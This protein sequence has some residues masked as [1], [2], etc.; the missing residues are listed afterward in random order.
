M[1][2]ETLDFVD[3][4]KRDISSYLLER[5]ALSKDELVDRLTCAGVLCYRRPADSDDDRWGTA[6]AAGGLNGTSHASSSSAPPGNAAAA[7][8][9]R[10]GGPSRQPPPGLA[11][12]G[13]PPH[14][15]GVRWPPRPREDEA[16]GERTGSAA[17]CAPLDESDNEGE[18]SE[19][20]D[21][22]DSDASESRRSRRGG[23]AP[24]RRPRSR[25]HAPLVRPPPAA[26][27]AAQAARPLAPA[28]TSAAD[29][30]E[31]LEFTSCFESGNLRY[32]VY[33]V[34][35]EA[36]DLVLENDVNTRGHTQWFYF[37]VRNGRPG[38]TVRLR[39]INMS[40]AK[41]LFRLGMRP[42]AWSEARASRLAS[43]L[44]ASQR[45]AARGG[46]AVSRCSVA[47]AE[48]LWGGAASQLW[49]PVGEHV[50]Y[51]RTR[52][53]RHGTSSGSYTLAF[54]YTFEGAQR[55]DCVFFAMGVPFTY[56]MLR[57]SLAAI[58]GD[59]V[60]RP[61]CRVKCLCSTLGDL[62][63]DLLEISNWAVSKRQK[64]SVVVSA[65]V[66]PGESNASWL[67]HGLLGFLLS[68]SP[69]AKVLR[70][71][72]VWQIVPMM[73]PDGVV[74]GNYRCALCGVDLNRQWRRPNEAL[75][76]SVHGLKRLIARSKKKRGLCMYID[77]HGH[78]R[79]TGLFSYACG[80]YPK[81]DYRRFTVRMY[82]KL[83]GLLTPEFAPS[84]C[85]W[86]VGKG[87]RGTGRVVVAKDLGLTETYT[88][89]ASFFG[90][91]P[92]SAGTPKDGG[93]CEGEGLG[94]S[95]LA[96]GAEDGAAEAPAAASAASPGQ[97]PPS[98]GEEAL[99]ASPDAV[100]FTTTK[101]ELFGANLARALIP[102]QNLHQQLKQA[103]QRQ[104]G[105]QAALWPD[106]ALV[107]KGP[108][109]AAQL[110]SGA[111][112]PSAAS[113]G[114]QSGSEEQQSEP[115]SVREEESVQ[116]VAALAEDAGDVAPPRDVGPLLTVRSARGGAE[117]C[118]GIDI[119]GV[120]QE[121]Q[122]VPLSSQESDSCGSDSAPSEDNLAAE[123]L[124]HIGRLLKIRQKPLCR[125]HGGSK[126]RAE[127]EG[128]GGADAA[129][130]Q[131]RRASGHRR[132]ERP[133]RSGGRR[134]TGPARGGG[135]GALAAR[136]ELHRI[137]AFG[138]TTYYQPGVVRNAPSQQ[139]TAAGV[140]LSPPSRRPP[141]RRG[142]VQ[143]GAP[144][145]GLDLA[146]GGLALGVTSC[147]EHARPPHWPLLP[148][149][150][151]QATPP[152]RRS[153]P[154]QQP[155]PPP[156]LVL[157][158]LRDRFAFPG[159]GLRRQAEG[160][161]RRE[162]GGQPGEEAALPRRLH[163]R[164]VSSSLLQVQRRPQ[165]SESP[166]EDRS[167]GSAEWPC[168]TSSRGERPV[169]RQ[170][171]RP[172]ARANSQR[173]EAS[174][175]RLRRGSEA[176]GPNTP[177]EGCGSAR[178]HHARASSTSMPPALA[179]EHH[180]SPQS[181]DALRQELLMCSRRR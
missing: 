32:V 163:M 166:G 131:R 160:R 33:S 35:D 179:R 134:G 74:C 143:G 171:P 132:D 177:R 113:E 77:L 72:F 130:K 75:H 105:H 42:V 23:G 155:P 107:A 101:L 51:H 78:S 5:P 116:F 176:W 2:A 139:F 31:L 55:S 58:M 70:D 48:R 102:H 170:S 57:A 157:E 50:R 71:H 76:S 92:P 80:Q 61:W 162:P 114:E 178:P 54:E 129:Q 181:K 36:Y 120:L 47:E 165:P 67:V 13:A 109:A 103:V 141:A 81:D 21:S 30:N 99:M 20:S 142:P 37:A 154:E 26:A 46:G 138:Q 147:P 89:E 148:Q 158:P 161:R 22:A 128:H 18:E 8:G 119:E 86:R 110:G 100:L 168:N 137:V 10:A 93:S 52:S 136:P 151:P 56:S 60:A 146:V 62:R 118:L 82:P 14:S 169:S 63:C 3:D 95:S 97:R 49:L 69:E 94:R 1:R 104:G 174:L 44:L 64:K 175:A 68:P 150:L 126:K 159:A 156:L 4:L 152:A 117:E 17:G 84:H 43:E 73:N 40:K 96:E 28:A 106:I 7:G 16:F 135:A 180:L 87:K 122:N 6:R 38:S 108:A 123:E 11:L 127:G 115:E 112:T 29:V 145:T 149:A 19:A 85:R 9:S 53:D 27:P 59:P 90:A 45:M 140:E 172:P 91:L 173:D 133:E 144:T 15:S 66:H 25:Q 167:I 79:K 111:T 125:K 88:I 65:R 121:L 39:I 34:E 83:L 41:S 24:D 124:A 153:T 12:F 98:A 164:N